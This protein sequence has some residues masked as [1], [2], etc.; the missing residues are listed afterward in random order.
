[1]QRRSAAGRPSGTDGSDYSFRMVVD[2]RY[3]KVAKGKGRLA[4]FLSI[5]ALILLVGSILVLL[6]VVKGEEYDVLSLASVVLGFLSLVAGE[7]GRRQSRTT[8]LKIYLIMSIIAMFISVACAVK[9]NV[10]F[11]VIQSGFADCWEKQRLQLIEVLHVFIEVLVKIFAATTTLSLIH[12]MS[13]PKRS[14]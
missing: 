5:Q 9:S 1:M 10:I 14:S 6:P 2:S 12:N 13:P 4:F 8:F 7:L 3:T 11:E